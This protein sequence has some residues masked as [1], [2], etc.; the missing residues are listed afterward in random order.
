MYTRDYNIPSS[1]ETLKS[2]WII[3][4][5]IWNKIP[6]CFFGYD[7]HLRSINLSLN[8]WLSCG[9]NSQNFQK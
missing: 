4:D 9:Y 7:F 8:C 1:N 6:F 5:L 3:M 2:G